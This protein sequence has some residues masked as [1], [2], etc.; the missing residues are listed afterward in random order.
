MSD[1]LR[2]ALVTGANAG[3]GKE[4]AHQLAATGRYRKI[5]LACRNRAKAAAAQAELQPAAGRTV[6]EVLPLDVSDLASVAAALT[7]LHEPIDD[8]VMNAGGSGGRTPL[9]VGRS[10]VTDIF[11]AR[12]PAP[13]ASGALGDAAV[14]DFGSLPGARPPPRV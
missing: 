9:A 3:I 8:L 6:F 2:V 11:G 14:V 12:T 7:A 5:Y 13:I 1:E 4:V 10:G